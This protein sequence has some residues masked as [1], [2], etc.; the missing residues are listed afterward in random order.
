[1]TPQLASPIPTQL[2]V[3]HFVP[4]RERTEMDRF[5]QRRHGL[6][7]RS[8]FRRFSLMAPAFDL[9]PR[10]GPARETASTSTGLPSSP[11]TILVFFGLGPDFFFISGFRVS[12]AVVLA[13]GLEG[14]GELCIEPEIDAAPGAR[15]SRS[16][17][18]GRWSLSTSELGVFSFVTSSAS[19][20]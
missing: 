15:R 7:D 20:S 19:P 17:C 4:Y 14:G 3:L 11:I 8:R 2:G 6:P 18:A 13:T 16:R 1:M 12:S 9:G 10:R 5:C